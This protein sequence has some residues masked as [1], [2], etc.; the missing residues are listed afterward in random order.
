MKTQIVLSGVGGQGLISTGEIMGLAASL[1]ED[2]LNATLTSSYGSE[3][4]GTFT[5][6]DVIISDRAIGYPNIESPDVI[7]CLAQVAYDQ[8]VGRFHENTK[9]FYDCDAVQPSP[10]AKG[11]AFGYPFRKLA[12]ELGNAAVTNTIALG[13]MLKK[14]GLFGMDSAKKAIAHRFSAKPAVV[15]LNYRALELGMTL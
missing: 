1:F 15:E 4:R 13:V 6:S 7:L 2:G 5:K 3:T 12:L 14:T 10:S 8:Y 11:E 9:V